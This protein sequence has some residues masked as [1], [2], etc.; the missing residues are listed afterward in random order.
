[1]IEHDKT[2]INRFDESIVESLKMELNEVLKPLREKY[3][4][5]IGVTTTQVVP[6]G[7]FSL[8]LVLA[9]ITDTGVVMTTEA[10][11]YV[12]VMEKL[13]L[14][15]I[16]SLFI[17]RHETIRKIIGFKP[18]GKNPVI[19]QDIKSLKKKRYKVDDIKEYFII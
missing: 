19:T 14:P 15:D 1:M 7:S 12:E 11:N 13:K 18:G 6:E 16:G 10:N 2:I 3:N 5:S 17:D 4:L 8:K 9:I